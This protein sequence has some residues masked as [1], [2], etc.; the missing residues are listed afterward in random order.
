MPS[1]YLAGHG[2]ACNLCDEPR[3]SVYV[4]GRPTGDTPGHFALCKGCDGP[5]PTEPDWYRVKVRGVSS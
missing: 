5:H 1:S 4:P 2:R 3:V